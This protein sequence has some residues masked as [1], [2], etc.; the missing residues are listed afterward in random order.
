MLLLVREWYGLIHFGL[1]LLDSLQMTLSKESTFS[2]HKLVG[3]LV[4]CKIYVEEKLF[5]IKI[6]KNMIFKI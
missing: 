4:E 3:F 5:M 6:D 1:K 2:V